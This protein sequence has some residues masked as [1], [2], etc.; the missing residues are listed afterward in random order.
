MVIDEVVR[1]V[2]ANAEQ[3]DRDGVMAL[4]GNVDNGLLEELL[5]EPFIQA[6]PPKAAG[7]EQYGAHFASRLIDQGRSRSLSDA[8][9]VATATALTVE[10]IASSYERFFEPVGRIDEVI[11]G[12]GGAYNAGLMQMLRARLAPVQLSVDED[13]GISSFAKEALYMSLITNEVI[14]GH[15]NNVPSVTGASRPVTMGLIALAL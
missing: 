15:P 11:V 6:K 7:R 9:L 10:S 13:Y 14:R 12:G 3:F 2:T 5:T 1:R 8:D 4:A